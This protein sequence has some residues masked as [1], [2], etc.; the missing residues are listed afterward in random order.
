M[1]ESER[2]AILEERVATLEA[3]LAGSDRLDNDRLYVPV[4]VAAFLR[5]G[6]TNVYDLLTAGDLAV[7]RVGAGKKGLRVRGSDLRAFLDDRKNGGP[8]PTGNF[9][10]LG[11]YLRS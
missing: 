8:S 1:V 6:K 5:C 3:I 10:H 11:K 2:V 4:E 9:K 7:T